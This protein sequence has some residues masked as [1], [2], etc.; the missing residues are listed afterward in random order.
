[1]GLSGAGKSTTAD[2][3]MGLLR[4]DEGQ[5]TIDGGELENFA[6]WR[7]RI[8][9]V[10]QDTFL[11]ND[12]VRNNLLLARNDAVEKDLNEVLKISSADFV[13][14]LPDGLDTFIGD[15]GVRLS[16]GERQR[17]ALARALLRRPSLLI[18]DEATSNLD[19]KNEKRILSSIEKLH[20]DLTILMIAHRFSTI[21]SA[22]VIYLMKEGH[23][24]EEG[25]WE[26]FNSRKGR[27]SEL[28]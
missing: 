1:V 28:F 5:I 21:E 25:S 26:E 14:D 18:M 13:F 24:V 2:L 15:R 16:G 12:T 20:G 9:Y 8:G 19:S 22:D 3:V 27:F 11:F 10:A 17:L 6:S 7:N 23:I 4:P